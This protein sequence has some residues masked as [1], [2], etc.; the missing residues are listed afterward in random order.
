MRVGGGLLRRRR[1]AMKIQATQWRQEAGEARQQKGPR[2]APDLIVR[3]LS[4]WHGEGVA[5]VPHLLHL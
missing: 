3:R 1:G 5:L 2:S 4:S